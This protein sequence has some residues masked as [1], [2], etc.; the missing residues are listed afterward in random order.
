MSIE[1][2]SLQLPEAIAATS[3]KSGLTWSRDDSA[4]ISSATFCPTVDLT[5]HDSNYVDLSLEIAGTEVA[6]EQ[7][8]TGDTGDL[9]EGTEITLA[10][11]GSLEIQSGDYVVFKATKAG[12]GVVVSGS[13]ELKL[14]RYR[15]A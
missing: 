10:L 15:A 11:S 8:T 4:M 6:S 12:S 5:A 1:T 9:T 2:R 7:T 3:V 14:E 13:C